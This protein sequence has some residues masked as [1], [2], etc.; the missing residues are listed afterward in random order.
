LLAPIGNK[1]VAEGQ[2]LGFTLSAVDP[3][4]DALEFMATGLPPGAGFDPRTGQLLW[5]P[6]L[7]QA[8]THPGVTFTATDGQK[9]SQE[10]ITIQVANTNQAPIIAPLPVQSRRENTPL[11]FT[12]AAS[13]ADGD[14]LTLRVVTPLPAGAHFDPKSRRFTW[15][16]SFNQ[17]GTYAL[18]FTAL[19]TGSLEGMTTVLVSIDNVNRPPS[20]K[21]S[22]HSA[23]LGETLQSLVGG[24]D[25]DLDD[26]LNYRAQGLPDGAT[27]DSATGLFRWT[28]GPGQAG[29]YPVTFTV[30]DG[31]SEAVRAVNLHAAVHPE[32]PVVTVELTPSFP[33]IPGQKV[34][35]HVIARSRAE[36]TGLSLKVDGKA[37]PLD[38]QGR[39]GFVAGTPGR[40]TLE[41]F[42]TDADGIVGQGTAVL[43]VRD[44]N[45]LAAPVV[46]FA[47]GLAGAR[48]SA[49]TAII[50]SIEDSNLNTWTLDIARFG[51]TNFQ[52]LAGGTMPVQGAVLA[53]IDPGLLA[54]G[55]YELRLRGTDLG[56]RTSQ[57]VVVVEVDSAAKPFQY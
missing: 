34:V 38:A 41:A 20:R 42:A 5:T 44:P 56:G 29:D 3:D 25:A 31:V 9:S 30:S 7:F 23:V 49:A 14:V 13:G 47:P 51:S 16:P 21:V 19:D 18:S 52:A 6:N 1:A 11:Q 27:L 46:A 57:V 33:V 10:T 24:S 53:H 12:L 32:L 39:A 15:T 26:T 17:A 4:G 28:P 54:N 40:V 36:I 2:T 50:G 37:L 8:G 22:D 48:L 35:A 43:W 55:I 45:D